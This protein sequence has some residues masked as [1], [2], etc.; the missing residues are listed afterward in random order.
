MIPLFKVHMADGIYEP[1]MKTLRSG[2][3]GEGPK[4][5]QFEA[6]LAKFFDWDYVAAT[7]S[8]TSAL[9]LALRVAGVEPGDEVMTSPMT[10]TATNMAIRAVGA[11]IRWADIDPWT[12]NIDPEY[13]ERHI[14]KKTKAIIVVWWAGYPAEMDE[15]N[16]IADQ[17]GVKVI[18]DA[19][20]GFGSK[21][22]G[23]P[24]I[25]WLLPADYVCY[26]FGPIKMLSCVDGGALLCQRSEDHEQ[27]KLLRWYGMDRKGR[28]ELRCEA[29]IPKCGYKFHMN[30]VA[31]TIGIENLKAMP[32]I[33]DR[34][35]ANAE[36][37]FLTLINGFRLRPLRYN[38]SDRKCVN[39]I[40]TLRADDPVAFQSFMKE[41]GVHASPV[42][43][44]NDVHSCFAGAV[45]NGETLPGLDEF[46]ARH[47]SI[48]VGWWLSDD[49]VRYI[50]DCLEDYEKY[51][52]E[53]PE[54]VKEQREVETHA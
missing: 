48:P 33:I 4:V 27:A 13:I 37:Y 21:Y 1:V 24:R 3:V 25:E 54:P 51:R 35:G 2:Y 12:G 50:C 23:Q 31:A 49:E 42:H 9:Q 6:D 7:N 30:D 16:A 19:A 14:T 53:H 52:D 15:I 32:R 20:H 10:C 8:C 17:H 43:M 40:Y 34:H 41:R 36:D 26:S 47:I 28:K 18:V 39:W 29:D 46:S 44:R 5:E 22:Y 45:N 11:K 38:L